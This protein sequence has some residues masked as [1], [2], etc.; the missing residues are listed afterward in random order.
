MT[1]PGE[2]LIPTVD[3]AA[4]RAEVKRL[5]PPLLRDRQ[6]EGGKCGRKYSRKYRS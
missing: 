4:A 2:G 3:E 6:P 1:A 5:I